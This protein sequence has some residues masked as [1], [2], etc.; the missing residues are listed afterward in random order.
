MD[1]CSYCIAPTEDG[2][3]CKRLASCS[4]TPKGCKK[5][6][7]QH[8]KMYKKYGGKYTKK[9]GCISPS[10]PSCNKKVFPCRKKNTIF[11]NKKEYNKYLKI[12]KQRGKEYNRSERWAVAVA[13]TLSLPDKVTPKKKIVRFKK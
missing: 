6:C 12:K 3:I 5:F 11:S 4:I 1:N 8:A 10:F 2:S 9:D 13:A 7:W